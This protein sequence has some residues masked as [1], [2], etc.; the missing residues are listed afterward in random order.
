MRVFAFPLWHEVDLANAFPIGAGFGQKRVEV[1]G[2]E[3]FRFVVVVVVIII[4]VFDVV[5]RKCTIRTKIFG[6]FQHF[7][8]T[9]GK[10]E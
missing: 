2:R 6:I 9:N 8:G 1:T 3:G 5:V 10:T 7:E 4:L